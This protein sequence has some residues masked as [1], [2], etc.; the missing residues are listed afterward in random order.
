MAQVTTKRGSVLGDSGCFLKL[1]L[2]GI[3]GGDGSSTTI[4]GYIFSSRSPRPA[5]QMTPA[6]RA[7]G[8]AENRGLGQAGG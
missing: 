2:Y 1:P 8:A 7:V 5:Q 3:T 4:L 6:L